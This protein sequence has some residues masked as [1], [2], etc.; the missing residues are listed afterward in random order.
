MMPYNTDPISLFY[1][2]HEAVLDE[3]SVKEFSMCCMLNITPRLDQNTK[4]K[5]NSYNTEHK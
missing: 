3:E 5:E 4:D 1:L 2:R